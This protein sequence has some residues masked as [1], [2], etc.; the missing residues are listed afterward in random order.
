MEK[1][2]ERL[3]IDKASAQIQ[4]EKDRLALEKASQDSLDA[5]RQYYD[6]AV[7]G[8][9]V[10]MDKFAKKL[11][12]TMIPVYRGIPASVDVDMDST[13]VAHITFQKNTNWDFVVFIDLR[14]QYATVKCNAGYL[15]IVPL[16]KTLDVYLHEDVQHY[17]YETVAVTNAE[18]TI[19]NY[20][21]DLVAMEYMRFNTTNR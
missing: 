18:Q 19:A 16:G 10:I 6:Y 13:N 1:L 15:D 4:K 17:S 5:R 21:G 7:K 8:L 9:E 20:L 12:D 11:G 2:Q 14:R 3:R